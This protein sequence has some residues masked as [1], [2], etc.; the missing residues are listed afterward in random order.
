MRKIVIGFS[1]PKKFWAPFSWLIRAFDGFSPYSHT[2][3]RFRSE[4]YD[5]SLIY[6][7]SH[8]MVN[9]M[10]ERVFGQQAL[11]VRE[12]DLEINDET[13]KKVMTFA[14]D[15]AGEPYDLKSVFGIAMMKIV[16][17]FGKRIKN[18]FGN[19]RGFFCSELVGAILVEVIDTRIYLS[20]PTMTPRD[21]YEALDSMP[22]AGGAA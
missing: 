18:P 20:I 17:L 11:I 4:K 6:Q 14:I 2:Y 5:R 9:L 7:A 12:F 16:A 8:L 22:G 10:G 21:I 19:G 15:N 3:V 1:R 13:L